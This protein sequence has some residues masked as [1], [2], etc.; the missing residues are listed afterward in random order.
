MFTGIIKALGTLE[1]RQEAN[2]VTTFRIA[3][4]WA[5]DLEVDESI[6]VQGVCLTVV[7]RTNTTFDV[8]VVGETLSKT[9]LGGWTKGQT[10]NL[11]RSLRL[12]QGLSGHF[13]Q[14]HVDGVGRVQA[15]EIEEDNRHVWFEVSDEMADYVVPRG[16]ITVD[17]VSL[18][19]ARVEG[20]RFMITIIPY[21]WDHTCFATLK[22]GD[23]V[24]IE[25]DIITKTVVHVQKRLP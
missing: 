12:D 10:L 22:E 16:S 21:T 9:T 17:G 4:D 7:S 14:G 25:F 5:P 2:G 18:T 19:L 11:E 24:N 6:A 23:T 15:I 13:V 3:T 1:D 20:P 8:N